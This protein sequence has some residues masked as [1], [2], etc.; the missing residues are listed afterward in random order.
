MFRSF[1][2][3]ILSL[4]TIILSCMA[5][6]THGGTI[7]T[8]DSLVIQKCAA[9]H[10]PDKK[11]RLEVLEETRKTPEEWK[12]VVDRM[13]RLND[14][15]IDDTEFFPHFCERFDRPVQLFLRVGR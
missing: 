13:I 14:A 11:G 12:V 3:G 6:T 2:F 8:K 9:C 7:F 15:A 4:S 5:A 1:R 10:Q